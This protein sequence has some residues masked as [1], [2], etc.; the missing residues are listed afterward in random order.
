MAYEDVLLFLHTGRQAIRPISPSTAAFYLQDKEPLERDLAGISDTA[1]GTGARYWLHAED[2]YHLNT[3]EDFLMEATRSL[4]AAKRLV[5]QSGD[6]V[7][8]YDISSITGVATP[9][10]SKSSL[11]LS[12]RTQG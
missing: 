5:F 10:R 12:P 6:V 2:D 8:I 11:R 7:R 4:L 3:A 1:I 9:D